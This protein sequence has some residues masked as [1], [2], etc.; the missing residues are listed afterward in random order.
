MRVVATVVIRVVASDE[1]V[2]EDVAFL[3][4]GRAR[5]RFR[6]RPFPTLGLLVSAPRSASTLQIHNDLPFEFALTCDLHRVS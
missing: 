2:A 6:G 5:E 4:T 1:M 3:P